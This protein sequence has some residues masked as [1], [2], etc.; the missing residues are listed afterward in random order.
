MNTQ[1]VVYYKDKTEIL[2]ERIFSIYSE[3]DL[4]IID[5]TD[6]DDDKDF[7]ILTI[8]YS[9]PDMLIRLGEEIQYV[10]TYYQHL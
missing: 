6:Y 4:S 2:R 8:Q 9:S 7:V 5:V 3:K 1:K 10:R